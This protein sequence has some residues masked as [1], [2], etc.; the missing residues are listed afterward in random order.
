MLFLLLKQR[1]MSHSDLHRV[2]ISNI[3][4]YHRFLII[5]VPVFYLCVGNIL[6]RQC[7]AKCFAF[8]P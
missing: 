8:Y 6:A 2:D 1:N 4:F 7:G 5:N 3:I